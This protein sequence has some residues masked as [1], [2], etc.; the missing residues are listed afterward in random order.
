ML[1]K[2]FHALA[3]ECCQDTRSAAQGLSDPILGEKSTT[4]G[5]VSSK[6]IVHTHTHT[7][8]QNKALK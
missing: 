5:K 8:I 6:S 3:Q 2:L 4:L 7:Q 1:K